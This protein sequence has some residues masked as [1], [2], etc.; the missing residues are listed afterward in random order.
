MFDVIFYTCVAIF[1]YLLVKLDKWIE[2]MKT[3][4]Y[5]KRQVEENKKSLVIGMMKL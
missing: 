3:K 5:E 4:Y 2:K 1:I